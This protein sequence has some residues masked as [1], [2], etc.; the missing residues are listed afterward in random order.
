MIFKILTAA[1]FA[2]VEAGGPME[3]PVDVADGFVH[4]S[5][6]RQLA[7]TLAKYFRGQPGLVLVGVTCESVAADLRW[8]R[9]RGGDFFPHVYGRLGREQIARI[10]RLTETTSE[11]A[12]LAPAEVAALP[13]PAEKPPR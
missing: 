3:A 13:E 8:E 9:S 1:Q 10:W 7:E 6:S 5:T 4:L 12:P 2:R 11:G